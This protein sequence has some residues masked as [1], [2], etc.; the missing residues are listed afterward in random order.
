M[1]RIVINQSANPIQRSHENTGFM[2]GVRNGL[3]IHIETKGLD[4]AIE[5]LQKYARIGDTDAKRVKSGMIG[6]VKLVEGNAKKTVPYRTGQMKATLFGDHK[7]WGEGN[8]TGNVGSRAANLPG[9]KSLA[10]F[11]LEGGRKG[12]TG[13]AIRSTTEKIGR[14]RKILGYGN[15]G[16]IIPRRWLYHAYSR[17][18]QQIDDIWERVLGQ[19]VN[20][21][22]GRS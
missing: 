18:K 4:E 8:V 9:S 3:T 5:K 1:G 20:D 15:V 10:P 19:I 22:S 17:A 7:V 6:T 2:S 14:N 13:Q 16:E 12:R 21:L 11:V